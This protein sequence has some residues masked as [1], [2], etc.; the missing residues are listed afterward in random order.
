MTYDI[1]FLK[2]KIN[3][4][5]ENKE[6]YVFESFVQDLPSWS[7]I[8]NYFNEQYYTEPTLEVPSEF[9]PHGGVLVKNDYEFQIRQCLNFKLI[10]NL[11][12]IFD[13]VFDGETRGGPVFLD[14]IGRPNGDGGYGLHPDP[15]D[16]LHV[17]CL[18]STSWQIAKTENSDLKNVILNPGDIIYIPDGVWHKVQSLTPRVGM[19]LN[20]NLRQGVANN[21]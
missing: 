2:E 7:D 14:L 20:Y 19:S 8:I 13:Q 11:K 17:Q 16:N 21:G 4:A 18:G 10:K 6:Y 9:K 5:N 3:W 15:S 1:N 12:I